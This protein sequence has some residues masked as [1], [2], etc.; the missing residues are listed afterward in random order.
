MREIVSE[1][2]MFTTGALSVVAI[3]LGL[4]FGIVWS[5]HDTNLRYNHCEEFAAANHMYANCPAHLISKDPI[6]WPTGGNN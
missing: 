2:W 3:I 4:V 5:N 1:V 6:Q